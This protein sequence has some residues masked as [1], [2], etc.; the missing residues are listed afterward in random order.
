MSRRR[1][2]RQQPDWTITF[3]SDHEP[4][5]IVHPRLAG[6]RNRAEMMSVVTQLSVMSVT[7]RPPW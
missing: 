7:E 1:V 4:A 3:D 6:V 5:S 2:R